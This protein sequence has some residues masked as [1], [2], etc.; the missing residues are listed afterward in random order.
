MKIGNTVYILGTVDHVDFSF[1]EGKIYSKSDDIVLEVREGTEN[2]IY[3]GEGYNIR[4]KNVENVIFHRDDI[5]DMRTFHW[6]VPVKY[7]FASK[8]LNQDKLE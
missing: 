2:L 6:W 5:D 7:C 3:H 1:T 4:F 8:D